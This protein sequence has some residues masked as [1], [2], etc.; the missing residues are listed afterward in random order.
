MRPSAKHTGLQISSRAGCHVARA[1]GIAAALGITAVLPAQIQPSL[2]VA[3]VVPGA[4]SRPFYVGERLE[5]GVRLGAVGMS[6]RGAMWVE[7]PEDVRGTET[8]V[9][10]FGFRARVGPVKVA[11]ATQSWL[12]P[13]R[14]ASLRFVKRERHPFSNS[15]LDVALY[16]EERRWVS[17]DGT[18][19]ESITNAPLDELS[20]IYFLRTVPLAADSVYRFDRHFDAARNPTVVRVLR[21]ETLKT[22]AG[23]FETVLI[24]M[25]VKDPERYQGEGVIRIHFTDDARRLPVRIESAIPRAGTAVLTLISLPSAS[26]SLPA[27]APGA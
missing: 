22:S 6:G 26:L 24:E 23:I 5:Y 4:P 9:L 1:L 7:G 27:G 21:R 17:A 18:T 14:M 20:F 11:D 25:R 16:P 3:P 15:D 8:Y 13:R 12:D 2:A 10:H 19:G